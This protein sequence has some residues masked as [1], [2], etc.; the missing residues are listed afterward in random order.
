MSDDWQETLSFAKNIRRELHQRPEL[1]WEEHGTAKKIRSLL[2]D[3]N[4]LESLR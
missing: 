1:S 4:T 2:T 3:L